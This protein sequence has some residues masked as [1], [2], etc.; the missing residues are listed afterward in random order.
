MKAILLATLL[1]FS[2]IAQ[3]QKDYKIVLAENGIFT[4]SLGTLIGT[5]TYYIHKKADKEQITPPVIGGMT[6]SYTI[7]VGLY[8]I[9]FDKKPI[10]HKSKHPRWL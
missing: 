3:S 8:I 4:L 9:S 7:S 1:L 6:F 2:P 5:S 10:K